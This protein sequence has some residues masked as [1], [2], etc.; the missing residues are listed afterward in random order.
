MALRFVAVKYL[1]D[2]QKQDSVAFLQAVGNI[3]MYGGY[4]PER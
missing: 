3:F 2:L 1:P 4:R